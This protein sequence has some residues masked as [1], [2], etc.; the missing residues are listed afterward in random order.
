[1]TKAILGGFDP[2]PPKNPVLSQ[3][4]HKSL[5]PSGLTSKTDDYFP[6]DLLSL[7]SL[8]YPADDA[9]SIHEWAVYLADII[10]R[11]PPY[12]IAE[13][14]STQHPS[15]SSATST[16]GK[17]YLYDFKAKSP[18][19]KWRPGYQKAHHAVTD[20]FLFNVAPDMVPDEH[21]MVWRLAVEQLQNAWIKFCWGALHWDAIGR[22]N[23]RIPVYVLED[24][25][26]WERKIG[27]DSVTDPE[28]AKRW[29]ALL[30]ISER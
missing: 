2:T 21:S 10:F 11:V 27:I 18:Y 15:E 3:Q 22:D 30:T 17:I 20:I 19:P 16:T 14:L 25:Y 12:L 24:G 9:S 8:A 23:V 13:V 5:V 6:S 29:K 26:V 7:Y 1:M 4:I 28:G